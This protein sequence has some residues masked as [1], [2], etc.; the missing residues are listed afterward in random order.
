[1]GINPQGIANTER[2]DSVVISPIPQ[3]A[4]SKPPSKTPIKAS[5]SQ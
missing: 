4:E 2:L 3:R 5:Q 1:M